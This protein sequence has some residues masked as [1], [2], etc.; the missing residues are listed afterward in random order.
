M[1]SGWSDQSNVIMDPDHR[2]KEGMAELA[3]YT[4]WHVS[5]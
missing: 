5:I 2:R 4:S 1:L 3:V